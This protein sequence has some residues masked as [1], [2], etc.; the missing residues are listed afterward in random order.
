MY[1]KKRRS[2]SRTAAGL[3][4]SVGE[5]HHEEPIIL[6]LASTASQGKIVA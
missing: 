5:S 4:D 2:G 1:Q 3:I 6:V